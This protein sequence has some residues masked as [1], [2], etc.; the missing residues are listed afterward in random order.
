MD[1]ISIIIPCYNYQDYIAGT[2]LSVKN[3][4]SD[5]WECVIVDDGSTDSS[6][7]I[8]DNCVTGD[9]RFRVFH[10]ENRG[11][12][13]ARNLA[14]S[15]ASGK[16]ILPLD[17]DDMLYTDAVKVFLEEWDKHIDAKLL[18][19]S[20]RISGGGKSRIVHP[21]WLGFKTATMHG[22]FVN[23]SCY[24]KN[25]WE[26]AGGYR[27]GT[28]Y[29]DWDFGLRLLDGGNDVVCIDEI[30]F[31]HRKHDDSRYYKALKRQI[32][33]L[34]ILIDM[35]RKYYEELPLDDIKLVV[36]PYLAKAA[37]GREL[38]LAIAGWR[39]HFKD[40]YLIVLVGD[41]DPIVETGNDIIFIDCPR[42]KWPGEGNYWAHVDHVR[43]FREVRK[44]FPNS[45]GFIYTCD[46]IY[47]T[48][49][50]TMEDVLKPKVREREISG[51]FLS[52]NKWV[53]DN[54]KTRKILKDRGFPTMNWVCHLPVYY[55]WDKLFAIYDKYDCDT[56]SRVV[57][58]LYFNI[59]HH[60]ADY[61]V[62]E[63]EENDYQFKLWNKSTSIDDFR[64]AVGKKMWVCNSVAGWN[65]EI[66]SIL[67]EHYGL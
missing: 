65:P 53:I 1:I 30:L 3:Q 59:Y 8:I 49:D 63:E 27:D 67:R 9:S 44:Y 40:K 36:I 39:K 12:S 47:A 54:Y 61:I 35:N 2:I 58:Q 37:Q 29:E 55:E 56:K 62:I 24:K 6:G 22:G 21:R 16:Y 64:S 66:E 46:D 57:E 31:E 13:A 10:T 23:T 48:R 45:N 18:V 15:N 20:F 11:V 32:D 60:D 33:E 5:R 28:M 38:E 42:V 4:T 52:K 34:K 14:I 43:K 51:S 7:D 41:Y 26:R 25:D 50:F 19:P 17:A